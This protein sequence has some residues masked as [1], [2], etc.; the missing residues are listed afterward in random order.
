M[1]HLARAVGLDVRHTD[2][3]IS[4]AILTGVSP[5]LARV[6]AKEP[7]CM[8]F[9]RK[10]PISEYSSRIAHNLCRTRVALELWIV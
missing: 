10:Y 5:F 7:D 2:A 1:A 8:S 9:V 4:W 3:R 6:E